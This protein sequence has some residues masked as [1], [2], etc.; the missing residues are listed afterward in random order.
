MSVVPERPQITPPNVP[1]VSLS[2]TSAYFAAAHPAFFAG[3]FAAY[4]ESAREL[5]Q[6][7]T[8]EEILANVERHHEMDAA[9]G[10]PST[11]WQCSPVANARYVIRPYDSSGGV[12]ESR[13]GRWWDVMVYTV[14]RGTHVHK[15]LV[16]ARDHNQVGSYRAIAFLNRDGSLTRW[17]NSPLRN[18]DQL[19]AMAE[20][21]VKV[22]AEDGGVADQQIVSD[23]YLPNSPQFKICYPEERCR[24]CNREVQTRNFCSLHSPGFVSYARDVS[25]N[26]VY[27]YDAII[28]GWHRLAPYGETEQQYVQPLNDEGVVL[29]TRNHPFVVR[30]IDCGDLPTGVN[31]H[32]VQVMLEAMPAV[33]TAA[34]RAAMQLRERLESF[35]PLRSEVDR[36]QIR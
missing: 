35:Q 20:V 16:K 23:N 25:G 31:F 27:P 6:D 34:E 8:P 10:E 7:G 14:Q 3:A 4:Q 2:Q 13:D 5:R 22:A 17:N 32:S 33:P 12:Q 15:R 26:A 18:E 21:L 30:G 11:F 19:Y 24:V 1:F 9:T 29:T 36:R 28:E